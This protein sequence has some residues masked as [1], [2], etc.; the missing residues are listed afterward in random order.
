MGSLVVSRSVIPKQTRK[1][2]TVLLLDTSGSMS[3][4]DPD[5][6]IDLLWK[7]VQ[8]IKT[9]TSTWRTAIFNDRCRWTS[10][11]TVP[12]PSG[13]TYLAQA[14]H[15][16]GRVSPTLI[17]LVTDGEPNDHDAALTAAV[18]LQCPINILYVGDP[19][20]TEAIIFCRQVCE[21]TKGTFAT[22]VLTLQSVQTVATTMR[23]MLVADTARP[24][25]IAL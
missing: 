22:E 12:T 1:P 11:E 17:T 14:F 4:G 13:Q 7:G 23:K 18:A 9:P 5:R 10:L 2:C 25:A 15:E 6:R 20:G 3:E 8:A 21:Q 19:N 24:S 16:V